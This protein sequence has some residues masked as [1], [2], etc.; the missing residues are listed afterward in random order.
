MWGRGKYYA[1][2][3]LL[4]GSALLAAV[5]LSGG[6]EPALST[7]SAGAGSGGTVAALVTAMLL[8]LVGTLTMLERLRR[9]TW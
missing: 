1:G 5:A 9:S 2:F 7:L 8:L 3:A 4:A 6:S